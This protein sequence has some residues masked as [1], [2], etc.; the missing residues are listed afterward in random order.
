MIK[1]GD[2]IKIINYDGDCEVIQINDTQIIASDGCITFICGLDCIEHT[3][4]NY[5]Y[6]SY[7][8]NDLYK[9]QLVLTKLAKEKSGVNE[10]PVDDLILWLLAEAGEALNEAKFF[11]YCRN[12]DIDREK[13]LEELTDCLF[14]FLE[15]NSVTNYMSTDYAK[16]YINQ[17]ENYNVD[18]ID[19][20]AME[21]AYLIRD[22]NLAFIRYRRKY[23]SYEDKLYDAMNI[24][25]RILKYYKISNDDVHTMYNKKYKINIARLQ[26]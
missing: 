6:E 11:K 21:F 16:S 26:S 2:K 25:V 24:Y 20:I 7:N 3:P 9:K 15:L 10:V 22:I 18:E 13:L 12:K 23:D 4:S 19:D 14:M 8:F 17:N 5:K 1:V